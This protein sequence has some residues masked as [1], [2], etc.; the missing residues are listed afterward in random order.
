MSMPL[1]QVVWF[2]IPVADMQR[3]KLFYETV[4]TL[5]LDEHRVGMLQM[6]WFPM[7]ET[8]MGAT[9]SLVKGDGYEPSP[10]GALIYFAAPDLDAAIERARQCGG[11]VIIG[12]TDIGEHGFIALIRDTEGNRIGLHC[13][14]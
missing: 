7:N 4:L 6:A 10:E 8:A 5:Q 1:N 3:A 2:E 12:R 14:K 9:G 13:L 11:T